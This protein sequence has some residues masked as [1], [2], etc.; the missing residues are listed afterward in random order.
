MPAYETKVV[1]L[2][3]NP[4]CFTD[5]RVKVIGIIRGLKYNYGLLRVGFTVS[6]LAYLSPCF[7]FK[8]LNGNSCRQIHPKTAVSAN[9]AKRD[10]DRRVSP[11]KNSWQP[12]ENYYAR[13]RKKSDKLRNL[14]QHGAGMIICRDKLI[15]TILVLKICTAKEGWSDTCTRGFLA[16]KSKQS[17][18]GQDL[19]P[20]SLFCYSLP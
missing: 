20:L 7:M 18:H 11:A 19:N 12:W 14:I 16:A 4:K 15:Y 13:D 9:A 3:N 10:L 8:N 1:K 2:C 5:G 17:I 6:L